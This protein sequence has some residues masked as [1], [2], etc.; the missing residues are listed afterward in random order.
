L[1]LSLHIYSRPYAHA[2]DA[3]RDRI[4]TFTLI[5]RTQMSGNSPKDS[6]CFFQCEFTVEDADGGSCFLE[7]PEREGL[8]DDLED[9]SLRLLYRHRKT[10]AVGH[11]C[12]AQWPDIEAPQRSTKSKLTRC[13]PTK[14]NPSCRAKLPVLN[15]RCASFQTRMIRLSLKSAASLPKNTKNGLSNRMPSCRRQIS[16]RSIGQP[17]SNIL[18]FAAN[19]ISG[20]LMALSCCKQTQDTRL[21]FAWMNKAMLE[22]QL[23]YDLAAN[24]RRTWVANAGVLSLEKSYAPP[25]AENPPKGQRSVAAIPTCIH[26]DEPALNRAALKVQSATLLT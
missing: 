6:E 18:K 5:N 19:V 16:R 20:L 24:Q 10:F 9:Q 22:Q 25:N 14:S 7:Y 8:E 15:F 3:A 23:H 2:E 26:S 17:L 4:V 21:A 12:A 1:K 13:P 11:G